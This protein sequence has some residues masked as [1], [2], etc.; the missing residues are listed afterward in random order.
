METTINQKVDLSTLD[1]EIQKIP[2][3]ILLKES[4]KEVGQLTA[5]ID[6]LT[7][8]NEELKM[9]IRLFN[10]RKITKEEIIGMKK[11]DAYANM[12]KQLSTA[13]VKIHQLRKDNTD[14]ICQI[15]QLR[16]NNGNTSQDIRTEER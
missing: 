10:G 2:D 13:Q 6:H 1:H 5:E 14:L 16:K 7:A 15:V 4:R 8:E 11:E 9:K 12:K 3:F